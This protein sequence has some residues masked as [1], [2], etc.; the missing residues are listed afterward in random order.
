MLVWKEDEKKTESIKNYICPPEQKMTIIIVRKRGF[1]FDSE[2][3]FHYAQT[4]FV[5]LFH[6]VKQGFI[7]ILLFVFIALI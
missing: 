7:F 5:F 4:M 2:Y 6:S 1:Y 3:Q